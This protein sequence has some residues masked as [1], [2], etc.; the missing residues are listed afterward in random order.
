[1]ILSQRTDPQDL[2]ASDQGKRRSRK[3]RK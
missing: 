3:E 2:Q 1:M